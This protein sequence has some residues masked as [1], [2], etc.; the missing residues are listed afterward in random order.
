M[1]VAEYKQHLRKK[2]FDFQIIDLTDSR[3]KV[4]ELKSENNLG[5]RIDNSSKENIDNKKSTKSESTKTSVNTNI[6]LQKS[7]EPSEINVSVDDTNNYLK[8]ARQ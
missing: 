3:K 2:G 4:T 8:K 6:N 5:T 1:T 7:N